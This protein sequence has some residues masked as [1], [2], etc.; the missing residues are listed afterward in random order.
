MT[1][2]QW[3]EIAP[4]T[5]PATRPATWPSGTAIRA[6]SS[7]RSGTR[8]ARPTR[9][10]SRRRSRPT[11]SAPAVTGRPAGCRRRE[12]ADAAA[13]GEPGPAGRRTRVRLAGGDPGGA[14]GAPRAGRP[15]R[16][17]AAS[18]PRSPA[19]SPWPP[20]GRTR[21]AAWLDLCA[22]PGGK[23]RLLAGL[24]A[25]RGAR[26]IASDV[27]PH[28]ARPVRDAL[29]L[30]GGTPDGSG[31]GVIAADG[32]RAAL[33]DR[34]V[35]PGAGRR[36][37]LRPGRAAPPARGPLAQDPGRRRRARRPAARSC[38]ARPS[39]RSAPG[40]VV[41][42]V[43]CSPHLAETRDVVDRR[44]CR[45]G[46]MSP[47]STR[48]PSCPRFPACAPW[49]SRFAQFWPHRHGTDAMFLALLSHSPPGRS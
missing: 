26:L 11:T 39:T 29:A 12:L 4:R 21:P 45:P 42:Y 6:G 18:W 48:P 17:R 19:A 23:A 1:W 27:H 43:T 7:T 25:D 46:T 22:G 37:L 24:A 8:S 3:L 2:T 31:Y 41:A 13:G 28:R 35:R 5:P 20:P 14:L 32:T 40:G 36:A 15:S 38:S 33:G 49:T 16:T 47:S 10:S 44:R 9:P 34:H 30:A